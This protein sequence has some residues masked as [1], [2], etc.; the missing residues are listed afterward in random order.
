MDAVGG[1]FPWREV[2]EAL[3]VPVSLHDRE[4]RVLYQNPA[5][6]RAFGPAE[7]RRCHE[8][9]WGRAAPCD[10]CPAR[11]GRTATQTRPL[12][13][14]PAE[15][16]AVPLGD[17]PSFV[18]E[19]TAPR[20]P[21][22]WVL[23]T[24]HRAFEVADTAMFVE[25]LGGEILDVNAAAEALF[26][27]PREALVGRNVLEI[28]PEES[29]SLYPQVRE[30]LL[31]D[32]RFEVEAW[33]PRADGS[34]FLARVAGV[35]HR[36]PEGEFAVVTVRDV[37]AERLERETLA[38]RARELEGF[39][40][41]VAHDLRG[42]LGTVKGY[43]ALLAERLAEG[44]PE[45]AERLCGELRA[46]V[47]RLGTLFDDLLVFARLGAERPAPRAVDLAAACRSAW[48][49]LALRVEEAGARLILDDDLPTLRIAPVR[50]HQVLLNLFGNALRYRSPNEPPVV[51]VR[52]A[53]PG[54]ADPRAGYAWVV[55]EDNGIGIPTGME[56]RVFELF[57]QGRK[58]AGGSGVGLAIVR[59]IAEAEGGRV[60][61]R[62]EP[63]RGTRFYLELPEAP[64]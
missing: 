26:G 12:P 28:L 39:L 3:V 33:Q 60:F 22:R 14:G 16:T 55:V 8:F 49:D 11:T 25:E 63:G 61:A 56:E 23:D 35:L 7:G 41:A 45:G 31:R 48:A 64:A 51:R 47:E 19:W 27:M 17:G 4:F 9:L 18:L 21:R 30:T 50:L 38:E 32:G 15:T 46:Q 1:S 44:R 58:G 53:G 13:S 6:R 20:S 5:H 62:S 59:R 40:Y 2:L 24:L 42:P 36:D 52:K 57:V 10:P 54:E 34:R 29:R 43:A 37:T